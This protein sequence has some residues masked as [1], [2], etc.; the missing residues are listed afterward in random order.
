MVHSGP[1][2]RIVLRRGPLGLHCDGHDVKHAE[3][4]R[5]LEALSTASAV[6]TADRL[7]VLDVLVTGPV[8]A[9]TV[10]AACGI[11]VRGATA[12][13]VA[14]HGL[15][16]ASCDD[17]VRFRVE[18]RVRAGIKTFG[19]PLDDV[20]R[21]GKPLASGE[22]AAGSAGFYPAMVDE[23]AALLAP[24]AEA[25]AAL[26]DPPEHVLD[27][28]AGAAPW[29]IALARRHPGA[30]VTAVDLPEVAE[31]TR[32]AVKAAQLTD[33]VRVLGGDLFVADLPTDADLVLVANVCHLFE[34]E[35][36]LRLLARARACLRPGGTLAIVDVLP[37]EEPEQRRVVGLYGLGLLS[38][39]GVGGVHSEV[40]YRRWLAAAGFATPLVRRLPGINSL[41]TAQVADG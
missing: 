2:A 16:L 24:L 40:A 10:A 23:L 26:L 9:E 33:R 39:T 36:N 5:L 25:A 30:T 3:E 19:A 41:I 6:N 28:G 18:Q 29:S 27:L 22:T 12:L 17:G 31:V 8:D 20:L 13:L 1:A 37:S 4:L 11:S 15:G 14:L 32:R 7:G 35:T 38:R 34:E 21:S